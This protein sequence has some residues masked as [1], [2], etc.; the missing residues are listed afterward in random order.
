MSDA[1]WIAATNQER[2]LIRERDKLR[3][4][5]D[6]VL[7]IHEPT[8]AVSWEGERYRTCAWCGEAPFPED[9]PCETAIAAGAE[10]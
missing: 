5:L 7:V 4:R 1:E 9:Y 10:Q 3:A 2:G 8:T 6:A